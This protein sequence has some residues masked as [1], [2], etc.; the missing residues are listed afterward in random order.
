MPSESLVRRTIADAAEC[1]LTYGAFANIVTLVLPTLVRPIQWSL[2]TALLSQLLVVAVVIPTS[3]LLVASLSF[4]GRIWSPLVSRLCAGLVEFSGVFGLATVAFVV[5][6]VEGHGEL[7]TCAILIIAVVASAQMRSL[8]IHLN[9]ARKR[10]T[11]WMMALLLVVVPFLSIARPHREWGQIEAFVT[12]ALAAALLVIA[13]VRLS[14]SAVTASVLCPRAGVS[15]ALASAIGLSGG[16]FQ[17]EDVL[18]GACPS[19]HS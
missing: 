3:L 13:A 14:W 18:L 2:Q 15:L 9:S 7:A 6:V 5:A 17:K 8:R 19:I 16:L 11:C 4:V 12:A 10:G 1:A